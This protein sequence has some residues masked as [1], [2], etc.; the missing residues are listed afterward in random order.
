MSER[1]TILQLMLEA[2]KPE[3][4]DLP[5]HVTE[6]W[7]DGEV[8]V[9]KSGNLYSMRNS[10]QI[11]V[12]ILPK[13]YGVWNPDKPKENVWCIATDDNEAIKNIRKRMFEVFKDIVG[14]E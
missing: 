9:T 7:S 8:T 6:L 12:P 3:L 11:S 5:G 10:H 14:V 4:R 2:H 1:K 13:Q